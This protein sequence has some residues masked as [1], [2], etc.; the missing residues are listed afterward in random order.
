[1]NRREKQLTGRREEE[2]LKNLQGRIKDKLHMIRDNK[3]NNMMKCIRDIKG[4]IKSNKSLTLFISF[5]ILFAL[6]II[7]I[8]VNETSNAIITFVGIVLAFISIFLS[9][10]GLMVTNQVKEDIA[11]QQFKIKQQEVV[12]KLVYL[13]NVRT[14]DIL[15][16]VNNNNGYNTNA[17]IKAN[18]YGIVGLYNSTEYDMTIFNKCPVLD[19]EVGVL[20]FANEYIANPYLPISISSSLAR[21]L[22][23]DN[24]KYKTKNPNDKVVFSEIRETQKTV[25]LEYNDQEQV[26]KT[27]VYSDW[28]TWVEDVDSLFANI[29]EWYNK[30]HHNVEPNL[31]MLK[32]V[33]SYYP[34]KK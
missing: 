16:Q 14:Y 11:L 8:A 34:S 17:Y 20:L 7:I 27:K 13:L 18:L 25:P 2:G 24:Q 1:M 15:L 22:Q 26:N 21:L 12:D 3:F 32:R 10:K 19:E 29:R 6:A 31:L 30:E 23:N 9:Y 4:K 5:V 28:G 33:V